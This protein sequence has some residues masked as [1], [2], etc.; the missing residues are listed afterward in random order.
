MIRIDDAKSC[1]GRNAKGTE[2]LRDMI[3]SKFPGSKSMGVYVC[4]DVRG[5]DNLSVHGEGRA[6]DIG[7]AGKYQGDAVAEW[8]VR[9]ARRY[10]IQRVIWY[11]RIWD[12]WKGWRDYNGQNPHRDHVHIEQNWTGANTCGT[13]PFSLYF[14]G[15]TWWQYTIVG[16]VAIGMIVQSV[17]NRKR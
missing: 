10:Q 3:L 8:A 7:P 4:R 6:V 1:T 15:A 14:A 13:A 2:C 12:S 9:Y 5:A 17:R 16:A 11:G